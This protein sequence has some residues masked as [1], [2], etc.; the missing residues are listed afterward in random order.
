MTN[1]RQCL[2][3]GIEAKGVAD[4]EDDGDAVVADLDGIDEMSQGVW[5]S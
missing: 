2:T 3:G 5:E 4:G 1:N